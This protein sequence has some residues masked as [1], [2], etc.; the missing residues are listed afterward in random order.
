[1]AWSRS[2]CSCGSAGA[3]QGFQTS[4]VNAILIDAGSGAV[5]Y[6]KAPDEL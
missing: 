2:S 5:L 4:F 3:A 1:L 6:E